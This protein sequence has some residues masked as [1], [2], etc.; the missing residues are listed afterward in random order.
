M[1]N[2]RTKL[3]WLVVAILTA[4]P[5]FARAQN[6]D[7]CD[8]QKGGTPEGCFEE[9]F[10]VFCGSFSGVD[11]PQ[12]CEKTPPPGD[13]L[14]VKR[15][16]RWLTLEEYCLPRSQADQACAIFAKSK[17][18]PAVRPAVLVYDHSNRAWRANGSLDAERIERDVAGKPTV[19]LGRREELIVV[20]ENTN[21]LLYTLTAG[22]ATEVDI[23]ELVEVKKLA[24]LLGGNIS[25]LVETLNTEMA[26]RPAGDPNNPDF[27]MVLQQ[28][29]TS[30]Q[31]ASENVSCSTARI[32]DQTSRAGHFIQ[33]LEL[34]GTAEYPIELSRKNC[35]NQAVADLVTQS[36]KDFENLA[37]QLREARAPGDLCLSFL[38]AA[39][40]A[41]GG[42]FSKGDDIRKSILDAEAAAPTCTAEMRVVSAQLLGP[43]R[44]MQA[45]IEQRP[46]P[47]DLTEHLR[48]LARPHLGET[49]KLVALITRYGE[50]HAGATTLLGK[51]DEVRKAATQV[52]LFERRVRQHLLATLQNCSDATLGRCV[53]AES[54]SRRLVLAN[55]FK[56]VRWDK[57]QNHSLMLEANA[58]LASMVVPSG[59]AKSEA[60]YSLDSI[61]RGLWGIAASV[62]TT[63]IDEPTFTAVSD[64]AEKPKFTITKTDKETR[65]GEVALLVDYGL[66]LALFPKKSTWVHGFGLEFGAGTDAD[67]PAFFGGLSYRIGRFV[68]LGA[69]ISYQQVTEL[70]GQHEGQIVNSATD[71]RTRDRFTAKPYASFSV[72]LE[73]FTLFSSGDE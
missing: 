61:T 69:G 42:D 27:F 52:E 22:A 60:P 58:P 11:V 7:P 33:R 1:K 56:P 15:G 10:S 16:L 21:P 14:K 55:E 67:Q 48:T 41:F 38:Q 26:V 18:H 40:K 46:Q 24:G 51:R 6:P 31:S 29:L 57:I 13:E 8:F 53:V 9:A 59:P 5:G 68:R 12:V 73:A 34:G 66:G 17:D 20:V 25:S 63:R 23:P 36:D 71:L 30:L 50:V 54:V 3:S 62:V 35:A 37:R 28:V 32:T 4:F 49:K 19:S 2:C 70:E 43:L 45:A 39:E 65:A 47:A 72:A 44:A 64:G